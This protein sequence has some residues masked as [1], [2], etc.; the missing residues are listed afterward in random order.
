[1]AISIDFINIS[2]NIFGKQTNNS[3]QGAPVSVAHYVPCVLVENKC[4]SRK[5]YFRI[6]Y[7]IS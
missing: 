3:D 5:I 1:M 4:G 7:Y 6:C 2:T